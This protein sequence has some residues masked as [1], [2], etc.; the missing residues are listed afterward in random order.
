MLDDEVRV[1]DIEGDVL[2]RQAATEIGNDEAVKGTVLTAAVS[3]EVG[4]SELSDAVAIV[5]ETRRP[6]TAGV[7]HP[8]PRHE[9]H[10]EVPALGLDMGRLE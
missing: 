10:V 3:F 8:R 1:H 4:A 2:E 6:P 5:P 7:E 9:C